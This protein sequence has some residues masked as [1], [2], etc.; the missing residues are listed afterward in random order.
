[1]TRRFPL[2]SASA[3][4]AFGLGACGPD[5]TPVGHAATG[6]EVAGHRQAGMHANLVVR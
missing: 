5:D 6:D 1:M 3:A 4:L 2:I